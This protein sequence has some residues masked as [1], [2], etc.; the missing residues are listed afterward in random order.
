MSHFRTLARQIGASVLV[1]LAVFAAATMVQAAVDSWRCGATAAAAT[2]APRAA[3]N[4]S[5]R[6]VQIL[7]ADSL[8]GI[9]QVQLGRLAFP[10]STGTFHVPVLPF[11]T[12]CVS[13][14]NPPP[15]R[16]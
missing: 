6:Y 12:L 4:I 13:I 11:G 7:G 5:C 15:E 1:L 3:T 8:T 9:L 14:A 16:L 2:P 10:D